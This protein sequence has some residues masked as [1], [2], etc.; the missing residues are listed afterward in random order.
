MKN[1]LDLH[2]QY[3][4]A[5]FSYARLIENKILPETYSEDDFNARCK[6]FHDNYDDW[7]RSY[8]EEFDGKNEEV[9]ALRALV[10]Y[11]SG[12]DF[13]A[14]S[15]M[16]NV[17]M[18]CA[19]SSGTNPHLDAVMKGHY[20]TDK[21]DTVIASDHHKNKNIIPASN[22][23]LA[24]AYKVQPLWPEA[25]IIT[26]SSFE[27]TTRV[28]KDQGR[29]LTFGASFESADY[30]AFWNPRIDFSK[31]FILD[32]PEL[33]RPDRDQVRNEI[34]LAQSNS[35]KSRQRS[36]TIT[37]DW[38]NSRNSIFE[39]ARGNY[40]RFGL[41]PLR[42]DNEMDM[43]IYS[44]TDNTLRPATLIDCVLP[45]VQNIV[46]W[47]P[48]GI[49]TDTACQ[50]VA[51]FFHIHKMRTDP[52]YNA[53]QDFPLD[54][55][56]LD[57]VI[58]NPSQEELHAFKK[59]EEAVMPFLLKYCAHLI[60]PEGVSDAVKDAIQNAPLSKKDYGDKTVK[61]QR[62]NI[63]AKEALKIWD[64]TVDI[65]NNLTPKPAFP[66][67]EPIG[68]VYQP[69]RRKHDFEHHAFENTDP[70]EIWQD[71]PYDDLTRMM[72]DAAKVTLGVLET[73]ILPLDSP[74]AHSYSVDLK[75]GA[76]AQEQM[77]KFHVQDLTLL[78]GAMG[79]EFKK[80]VVIPNLETANDN[81]KRLRQ[82]FHKSGDAT[83]VFALG[84]QDY[85][86]MSENLKSVS[87]SFAGPGFNA[88]SD[89]RLALEMQMMRRNVTHYH[90]ADGWE[91]SGSEARKM[92][93][94]TKIQLGKVKRPGGN[95]TE[96]SV[97]DHKG[98]EMSLFDRTQKMWNHLDD[99]LKDP[100]YVLYV[101]SGVSESPLQQINS[102]RD[103]S[104]A[105]A[106]MLEI[107]D[108]LADP[109]FNKGRFELQQ[110]K[111][112][113]SFSRNMEKMDQATRHDIRQ[114]LIENW[115]WQWDEAD[116]K[117][118]DP[119]YEEAWHNINGEQAYHA[120][121]DPL[122]DSAIKDKTLGF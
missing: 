53:A 30:M 115:A 4:D 110:V 21:L 105:L 26:P 60:K 57:D 34:E 82:E 72:K 10:A 52:E 45:M 23:S 25:R 8:Y 91:V 32:D 67:R 40:V 89:F 22:R 93:L 3:D 43:R 49:A 84:S 47:A 24:R 18:N 117:D 75:G 16:T 79:K 44:E 86:T 97:L 36:N 35:S 7:Y 65:Q 51:R 13:I 70:D 73:G 64:L 77:K 80:K 96:I 63:P 1:G 19:I 68:G 118:L 54:L 78:P 116:L 59:L 81:I 120:G 42:P 69:Q 33:D 41:H 28:L 58:R 27:G 20:T 38:A 92:V 113:A 108:G 95:D 122:D 94:A 17:Y 5:D 39:T 6:N 50:T 119:R 66:K 100:D 12:V 62:Q 90:V 114:S 101:D 87:S 61:W 15:H 31:G 109:L 48:Q 85:K 107:Y 111:D 37:T 55:E 83:P 104:L 11:A 71:R 2:L 14:H 112:Q 121:P 76:I 98:N 46:R 88:N 74:N 103:V 56:N 9:N 102:A 99:L 29:E 106:R